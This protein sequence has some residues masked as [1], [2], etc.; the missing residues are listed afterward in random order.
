MLVTIGAS[1]Q[2][3][4]AIHR[5]GIALRRALDRVLRLPRSGRQTSGSKLRR[6]MRATVSGPS[7]WLASIRV[8]SVERRSINL[9][10]LGHFTTQLLVYSA[11]MAVRSSS[12]GIRRKLS[13]KRRPAKVLSS[14]Q[15]RDRASRSAYSSQ[16]LTRQFVLA[17]R[18]NRCDANHLAAGLVA[19]FEPT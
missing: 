1:E 11:R 16:S 9:S 4:S 15:G 13:P 7:R 19:S 8:S 3:C 10:V 14:Q 5:P 6:S 12:I 18:A 2:G 17:P